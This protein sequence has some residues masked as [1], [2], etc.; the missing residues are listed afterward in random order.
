M[1]KKLAVL[2]IFIGAATISLLI[3]LSSMGFIIKK[4]VN[5]VTHIITG[6]DA[7][8]LG[9]SLN[10]LTGKAQMKRLLIANP[11]DSQT[12]LALR[13]QLAEMQLTPSSLTTDLI[14]IESLTCDNLEVFWNGKNG[15]NFKI[16][17]ENILKFAEKERAIIEDTISRGLEDEHKYFILESMVLSDTKVYLKDGENEEE[18]IIPKITLS[19]IGSEEKGASFVD[20]LQKSIAEI[21]VSCSQHIDKRL[22]SQ[23]IIKNEISN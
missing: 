8:L 5:Q 17:E 22:N 3:A 10:L 20:L 1:K 13:F 18:F 16:I 7:E 4:T 23:S 21:C 12:P 11:K 6:T 9:S 15:E 14:K 2:G 19:D